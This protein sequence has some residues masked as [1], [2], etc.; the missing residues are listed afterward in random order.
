MEKHN[1]NKLVPS[2]SLLL[3]G[4]GYAFFNP[5]SRVVGHDFGFVGQTLS[6]SILRLFIILIV[7]LISRTK[8][9]KITRHDFVWFFL[10]A[11]AAAGSTL[12]YIPAIINLPFGLT[13]FLFYA[14]GTISSYAVGYSLFKEKLNKGKLFALFLII[15]G[16]VFMFI[17][18]INIVNGIFFVFACIS[19]FFYGFFRHF[20]KKLLTTIH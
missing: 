17:D 16:L 9:K 13:M 2:I 14:L 1:D 4:L 19:G 8:L 5:L 10:I 15:I 6:R 7:L 11:V 12:F 20:P 18:S 3:A